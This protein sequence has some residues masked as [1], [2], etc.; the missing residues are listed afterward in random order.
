MQETEYIKL[1]D[2]CIWE[3]VENITQEYSKYI[4]IEYNRCFGYCDQ[5]GI[6]HKGDFLYW[7]SRYARLNQAPTLMNP[8]GVIPFIM[9][10]HTLEIAQNLMTQYLISIL[11][12]RQIGASW[13]VSAWCEWNGQAFKADKTLLF[14][15]GELEATELLN[16]CYAIHAN[17]PP[18]F[19]VALDSRSSTKMSFKVTGSVIQALPSTENAGMSFQASRIVADEHI[20][21]EYAAKNY[22]AAK[23]TI[24]SG[25]GQFISIFTSNEDKLD[26]LAVELFLGG[27]EGKNG[28]KSL[29]FPYTVRPGRDDNWYEKTK[30]SIP[31]SELQGITPDMYMARNYP[32]S[33][34]EAL[35]P[36]KTIA[37]FDKNVLDSMM[38]QT[39][40]PK[41]GFP[42]IDSHIVH[43]YRPYT[44]GEYYV[45][46]SDTSHGVGKDYNTTLILN[47]K[48]GAVVA[49]I[50]D[51]KLS[52][53]ELAYHSVKLLKL[54]NSPIWF[55]EDNDWGRVTITTAQNLGYKNF[56]R[57]G[58]KD[59]NDK[60]GWHT[61]ERTRT[62][63]WGSLIPAVN[64]RQIVIYNKEGLKSL[65]DIIRQ[66]DENGRI[67][68]MSNR[69]DDYAMTL[70][71]AWCNKDKVQT[72]VGAFTP[73]KSLTF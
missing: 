3:P 41:D 63:I 24:D 49:D 11:K 45:A 51:N 28:F 36:S 9:W 30:Q 12:S 44:I 16:K 54:Y 4:Q 64:N 35:S 58:G 71:I 70:G 19:Q 2:S 34:E 50:Y 68:A 17:Q 52:P 56:G 47:V 57:Y 5:R 38:G 31:E 32:K 40:N 14:S 39:E 62:D 10:P 1:I 22:M 69:H 23:P 13:E 72:S 53:E 65:Y 46:A 26:S 33:I 8:G 66:A 43:I 7:L 73:L 18:S 25:G 55:I 29:F 59:K 21:H 6:W 37:V 48:T 20:E 61:D 60:I 67:E 42:D 15:K 27:R